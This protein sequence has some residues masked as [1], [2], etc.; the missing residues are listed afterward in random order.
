MAV[1]TIR[2]ILMDGLAMGQTVATLALGNCR[3][4]ALMAVSAGQLAMFGGRF[5]KI[6]GDFIVTGTAEGD[7]SVFRGYDIARHMRVMAGQTIVHLL[8]FHVRLMALRAVR[9]ETVFVM[10]EGT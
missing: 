8:S 10:A 1:Q 5:C 4:F 3:M 2:E 6:C 7:R 9:D